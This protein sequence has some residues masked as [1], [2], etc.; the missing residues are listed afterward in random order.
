MFSIALTEQEL[1]GYVAEGGKIE[2]SLVGFVTLQSAAQPIVYES[3]L[4]TAS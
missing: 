2:D 3:W 1:K 4:V